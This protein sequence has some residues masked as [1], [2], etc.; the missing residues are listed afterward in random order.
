MPLRSPIPSQPPNDEAAIPTAPMVARQPVA[1]RPPRRIGRRALLSTGGILLT[2]SV[3]GLL[4]GAST[5]LA[6]HAW[7]TVASSGKAPLA[8]V[9]RPPAPLPTVQIQQQFRFV[10]H[11][12]QVRSVAWSPDGTTIASAGDDGTV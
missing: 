8:P 2:C 5:A 7:G 10:G 9:T 3:A 6:Q 11:A 12:A 1:Q 4:T